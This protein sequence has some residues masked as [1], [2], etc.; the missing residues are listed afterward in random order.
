[1]DQHNCAIQHYKFLAG[2]ARQMRYVTCCDKPL[3]TKVYLTALLL[4]RVPC[5]PYTQWKTYPSRAV[6][7]S[8]SVTVTLCSVLFWKEYIVNPGKAVVRSSPPSTVPL[9]IQDGSE[10]MSPCL[11]MRV[12]WSEQSVWSSRETLKA[13]V[14]WNECL[15]CH[16][17]IQLYT[18]HHT[19][20][21]A[22]MHSYYIYTNSLI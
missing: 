15:V 10:R 22:H 2:S 13:A 9:C 19:L 7:S 4:M 1:M 21:V 17:V 3:G 18:V 14:R 11:Q 12:S 6:T 16:V 5:I 20:Y 8:T